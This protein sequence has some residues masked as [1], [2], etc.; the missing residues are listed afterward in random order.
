MRWSLDAC[1]EAGDIIRVRQGEIY[2]YGIF[3]SEGEVIQFG[4]P[5]RSRPDQPADKV[6]VLATDI[7]TF[8]AGGFAEVAELDRKESR[9]AKAPD[10]RVRAARSR[11]GERGYNIIYNNCEHFVNECTFGEHSCSQ[12]DRVRELFRKL[13]VVDLYIARLPEA[14]TLSPVY[15]KERWEQIQSAAC[16]RV[17][18]ERYVAWRLLEWALLRSFGM[19]MEKAAPRLLNTGK[20][21]SDNVHFSISHT[22]G[23]VAVAVSR[24]PVGVD[25]ELIAQR[26]C[27]QQLARRFMTER[28]L[29]AYLA[30]PEGEREERFTAAWVLREAAFKREGGST[31]VPREVAVPEGQTASGEIAFD[32][33][34]YAY[35]VCT[36]TPERLRVYSD[37][38]L[39]L[40]V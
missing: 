36:E 34:R 27:Q 39:E 10:E 7:D 32:A 16:E 22:E 15:P 2:H 21:V 28:E 5:P 35:A 8:L 19:K 4:L 26:E 23:A 33:C 31:F 20:W 13:P 12:V 3:V 9:R 25:I 30:A 38:K 17:R 18:R 24:A 40:E 37:V 14:V 6:E 1:P 11:L 29:D